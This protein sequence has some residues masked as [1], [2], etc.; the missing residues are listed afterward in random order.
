MLQAQQRSRAGYLTIFILFTLFQKTVA[1]L[2][3]LSPGNLVECQEALIPYNGGTAPYFLSVIASGQYDSPPL[4]SFPASLTTTAG[5]YEWICN[6]TG[7]TS[8][9]FELKDVTG[10]VAY[11]TPVTVQASADSSFLSHVPPRPR[12]NLLAPQVP[13]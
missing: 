4:I 5:I 1:Q 2:L 9:M 6:I 13:L 7:G 12:K 11:T 10:A 3:I 8:V